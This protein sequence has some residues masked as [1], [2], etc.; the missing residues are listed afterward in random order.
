[1][2]ACI[3]GAMIGES[4]ATMST[5]ST[6]LLLL[7]L[8]LRLTLT[9]ARTYLPLVYPAS[10]AAYVNV[11]VTYV[12]FIFVP[13]LLSTLHPWN[14][15]CTPG[16]FPGM[17]CGGGGSLVGENP[18]RSPPAVCCRRVWKA[19]RGWRS[20]SFCWFF[21]TSLDLALA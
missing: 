4:T 11:N 21:A 17:Q 7:P 1:M 6:L 20:T 9:L 5:L 16:M 2:R 3:L 19:G 8:L 15:H 13:A 12:F 14:A 18:T 10:V